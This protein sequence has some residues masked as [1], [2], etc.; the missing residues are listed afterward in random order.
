LFNTVT[1]GLFGLC[2][3]TF[4]QFRLSLFFLASS[5]DKYSEKQN[6]SWVTDEKATAR[7]N[8]GFQVSQHNGDFYIESN[9]ILRHAQVVDH[10]SPESIHHFSHILRSMGVIDE[11]YKQNVKVGNHIHIG[12]IIFVFGEDV[13]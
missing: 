5:K 3:F 7:P 9:R 4:S 10:K 2:G 12:Q 11:L 1:P 13:Y 8:N 6:R